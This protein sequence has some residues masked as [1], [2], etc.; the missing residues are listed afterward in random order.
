MIRAQTTVIPR[1]AWL[2]TYVRTF[3]NDAVV[4][5]QSRWIEAVALLGL[6]LMI[7]CGLSYRLDAVVIADMDEGTY[8]YGGKL[9]AGGL[10]PYRDF[11]LAHPPLA[12]LLLGG[13]ER[14]FGTDIMLARAANMAVVLASTVPLYVLT[15][16]LTGSRT[17]GL[18]SISTYMVGMLLL[19]NMG[20]TV[21]L[22]PL[23][24]AFLIPAFA[25]YLLRPD[26][27][28]ARFLVGFLFAL[29]ILVKLVAVVP[30]LI[31]V[32]GDLL[33]VRPERRFV[34]SWIVAGAGAALLFVPAAALLLS[35]PHFIDDVVLAQL[36]RPGM[37]F[38]GRLHYVWQNCIRYPLIPVALVA[39]AWLVLRARDPR[40]R[41]VALVAIGS[42]LML[43]VA[44]RTF[45]GYYSVQALPWMAVIIAFVACGVARWISRAWAPA[46]LLAGTLALGVGI[47]PLYAEVYTRTAHDHVSSPARIVSLLRGS[48]GSLYTMYPSFALWSGRDVYPWYYAVD[49]LIPRITGRLADEDLVRAFAECQALVL[50]PDELADYPGAREYVEQHFVVAYT[51][52]YWTLWTRQDGSG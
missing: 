3:R 6:L 11:L 35:Q 40:V 34:R 1:L 44:F 33:W 43:V 25:C 38:E 36:N 41:A 31:L 16:T 28:R 47:P 17:A 5:L 29:A 46:A 4:A 49:S 14:M 24:N 12:V 37:A 26:S 48:Q 22:E 50:F 39:S 2:P 52:Q 15:R 18:L 8:L 10:L 20:R 32:L 21:R 42:M 45:F 27:L 30:I 13:W 7:A 51:D 23:M 19:A 9:L